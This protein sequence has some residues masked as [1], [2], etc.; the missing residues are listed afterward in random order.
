MR[1]AYGRASFVDLRKKARKY[2]LNDAGIGYHHFQFETQLHLFKSRPVAPPNF[3]LGGAGALLSASGLC[4]IMKTKNLYEFLPIAFAW[5]LMRAVTH[6]ELRLM[7]YRFL[8][9]K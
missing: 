9:E 8:S 6:A 3:V 7:A 2:K 5:T 4:S 1:L